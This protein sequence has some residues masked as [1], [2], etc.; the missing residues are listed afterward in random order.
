[1]TDEP[2]D[3]DAFIAE[4][5]ERD[6]A[7]REAYER[8]K[9]SPH[10]ELLEAAI[11]AAFR[12]DSEDLTS[13]NDALRDAG[14][15]IS[16]GEGKVVERGRREIPCPDCG[17]TLVSEGG[18]HFPTGDDDPFEA[19]WAEGKDMLFAH[20]LTAL[21][22]ERGCP[23]WK[24]RRAVFLGLS[25]YR[26]LRRVIDGPFGIVWRHG[27]G[28]PEPLSKVG[29]KVTQ[30]WSTVGWWLIYRAVAAAGLIEKRRIGAHRP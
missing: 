19:F 15:R 16:F 8:A 11:D 22:D 17:R 18:I 12:V 27:R 21:A 2:D 28:W 20:Q 9:A 25:D 1:M 5:C 4:E 7:F 10:S 14:A 23:G 24:L 29:W 3:L 6:P 13:F 30:R 26:P